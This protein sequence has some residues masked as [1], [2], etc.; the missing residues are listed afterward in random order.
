MRL[1]KVEVTRGLDAGTG[2]DKDGFLQNTH[3]CD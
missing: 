1:W 2:G 3:N